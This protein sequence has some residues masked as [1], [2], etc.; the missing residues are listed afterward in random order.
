M[1]VNEWVFQESW[2]IVQHDRIGLCPHRRHGYAGG[3]RPHQARSTADTSTDH[4]SDAQ[5]DHRG[6]LTASPCVPLTLPARAGM[7]R[8]LEPPTGRQ[9]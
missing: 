6:F 9:I 8:H 3:A 2:G 5:I 4:G 7:S 1:T